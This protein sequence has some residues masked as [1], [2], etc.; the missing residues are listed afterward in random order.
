MRG[1]PTLQLVATGAAVSFAIA[2]LAAGPTS[3]PVRILPQNQQALL[4]FGVY[5]VAA[6]QLAADGT[7]PAD[8]HQKFSD[9]IAGSR[10]DADAILANAPPP[11]DG[12]AGVQQSALLS[13]QVSQLTRACVRDIRQALDREQYQAFDQRARITMEEVLSLQVV[14]P[15]TV[16][17]RSDLLG[18][19]ELSDQQRRR[20]DALLGSSHQQMTQILKKYP[21]RAGDGSGAYLSTQLALETRRSLRGVL[22]AEQLKR[23]DQEILNKVG[24]KRVR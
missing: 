23:W 10:A 18:L 24:G 12:A 15:D 22:T 7:I 4:F 5:Q 19:L 9:R 20:I 1:S 14:K 2:R 16:Y 21:Y 17:V 3:R 11:A 8:I 13:E 6:D